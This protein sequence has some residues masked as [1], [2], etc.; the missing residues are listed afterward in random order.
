MEIQVISLCKK[1]NQTQALTDVSCQFHSG[2]IYGIVGPNGSGKTMLLRALAGLI[3][4]TSG[5][6]SYDGR[7][8]LQDGFLPPST[9]VPIERPEYPPL[10]RS[11]CSRSCTMKQF[12]LGGAD[13]FQQYSF[14]LFLSSRCFRDILSF[15]GPV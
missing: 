14:S 1:L 11:F 12:I 6:A 7:T 9:G 15:S 13:G 4:P 2:V 10:L 8:L 5:E 3:R